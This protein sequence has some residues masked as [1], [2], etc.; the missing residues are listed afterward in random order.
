MRLDLYLYH[1]RLEEMPAR[2]GQAEA[3]GFD[4]IFV[5]ESYHDPFQALAVLA[6]HTQHVTLGTAIALA[7][8]RSPMLMAVSAWDLQRATGGRFVLGLGAQV[9]RHIERRFSAHYGRPA[10]HLREYAQAVRH[11]FG[12]FAGEHP[13]GFAGD[14]YALDF[15]PAA[16]NPGPLEV[17]APPIFLAA[18]GPVMFEAAGMVADGALVHPIHTVEYLERVAEPAIARGLERSGRRREDFT[19]SVTALPVVEGDAAANRDAMR[20]QFAF[21]ASTPAYRPVLELAGLGELHE[22]LHALSRTGD[23]DAMARAVDEAALESF[24]LCGETW[25]EV[26]AAARERYEGVADRVSF[27]AAPTLTERLTVPV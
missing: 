18:V 10:P 12:A 4:G 9:R 2:A 24:A 27:Q 13:L 11:I 16:V 26:A 7:F 3:G 19:L 14:M 15:L 20:R 5:A 25:N 8:P 22:R 17:P 1:P 6:E 23:M 21:Y